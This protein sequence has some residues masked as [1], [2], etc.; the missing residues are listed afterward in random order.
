VKL[1]ALF[2][3]MHGPLTNFGILFYDIHNLD[4]VRDL[5]AEAAH[6]PHLINVY[7]RKD[8]FQAAIKAAFKQ[9]LIDFD[10]LPLDMSELHSDPAIKKKIK[11]RQGEN[12]DILKY[13]MEELKAHPSWEHFTQEHCVIIDR[14]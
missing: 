9:Y 1:A 10:Q 5:V 14:F 12:K 11:A 3:A 6:L 2:E 7:V 4:D 8:E 13:S